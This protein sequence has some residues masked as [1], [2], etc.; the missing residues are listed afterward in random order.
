MGPS[1]CFQIHVGKQC[2]DVCPQLFVHNNPMKRSN[3][4][5]YL[6]DILSNN[7]KIDENIEA[8]YQ[9]GIG[10]N[11]TIFSLL[12]EISFGEFYFEMGTLFRS[13]MLITVFSAAVKCYMALNLI[14]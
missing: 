13:S 2:S 3:S 14:T 4:E 11:N 8:R 7:G 12:Q 10:V 5:K 6:G 9:K 1:K